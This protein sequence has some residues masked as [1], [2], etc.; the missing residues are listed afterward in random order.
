MTGIAAPRVG[1][2]E[3]A[4]AIVSVRRVPGTAAAQFD[5][6]SIGILASEDQRIASGS[7]IADLKLV[8]RAGALQ[9]NAL[10]AMHEEQLR[11]FARKFH[12]ALLASED[13]GVVLRIRN[14]EFRIRRRPGR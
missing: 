7:R 5:N 13:P 11:A 4:R 3:L 8:R 2:V 1:H 12:L 14:L 9:L 6:R 10:A